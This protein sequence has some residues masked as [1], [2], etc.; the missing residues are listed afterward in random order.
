MT[1]KAPAVAPEDFKLAMRRLA[2]SVSI[3]TCSHEGR[4]AGMTATAVTSLCLA[5]PSLLVCVNCS[6][7]IYPLI[8]ASNSFCVNVLN[9]RQG[10]IAALFGGKVPQNKRFGMHG[11]QASET[12]LPYLD[13]AQSVAF[14]SLEHQLQYGTHSVFVGQVTSVRITGEV[15]PLIYADGVL[16]GINRQ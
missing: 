15:A 5:P 12:G 16:S 13:D 11:W 4:R 6:A 14:C 7:S 2:A 9:D 8:I 1:V 10:A 3:I